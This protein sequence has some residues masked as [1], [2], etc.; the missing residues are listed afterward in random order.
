MGLLSS[1]LRHGRRDLVDFLLRP[2]HRKNVLFLSFGH[3]TLVLDQES[4]FHTND[5][6]G[7]RWKQ[8]SMC[9]EEYDSWSHRQEDGEALLH[10]LDHEGCCPQ[11][12]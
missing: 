9:T 2:W 5:A 7:L 12:K 6:T 11:Q 8:A 3:V 1:L 4:V 10:A